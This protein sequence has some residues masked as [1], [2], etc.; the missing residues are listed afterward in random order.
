MIQNF[1]FQFRTI[2]LDLA[3][4]MS[5]IEAR[6]SFSLEPVLP[7]SDGIDT[8]AYLSGDRS[9]TMACGQSENDVGSSNILGRQSPRTKAGLEFSFHRGGY[10]QFGRHPS[11]IPDQCIINQCYSALVSVRVGLTEK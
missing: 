1:G 9:L 4:L 7:K 5:A 10:F 6:Q 2:L 11:L 3:A 8:A